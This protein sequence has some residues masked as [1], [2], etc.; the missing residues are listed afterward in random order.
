MGLIPVWAVHF[1]VGLNDPCESFPTQNILWFGEMSYW[2]AR[3]NLRREHLSSLAG[4][5]SLQASAYYSRRSL[6]ILERRA[7]G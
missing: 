4:R 7:E 2:E 1:R 6:V 3:V 5:G